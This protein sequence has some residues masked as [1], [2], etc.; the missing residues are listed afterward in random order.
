MREALDGAGLPHH[1]GRAGGGRRAARASPGAMIDFMPPADTAAHR[2]A[3]GRSGDPHRLADRHRGRLFHRSGNRRSSIPQH[4]GD[5]SATRQPGRT[6][7]R[8]RPHPARPQRCAATAGI[9]PF[10]VMSCDNIPH[11]GVVTRNAVA[12]LARLSDPAAGRLDRGAM[13]PSRTAWSTA[14]R[15]ATD[16]SRARDRARSDFGIE[17]AWP[18]FCEEFRQ[19]VLEDNFPHGRPALEAGRRAVRRPMSRP[20]RYMKIRILNGGHAIIAYPGGLL[21]IHFVHEAMEH[22]LIARFLAKVETRG[23]HPDR[24]ARAGHRPAR[25]LPPDRAALLQP[26]DRRHDPAAV[27]RRLEPP[28]QVHR[29]GGARPPDGGRLDRRAGARSRRCGAATATA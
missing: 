10:T 26:E 1:R 24:A 12:G 23:D 17:D 16:G 9:Q 2:R 13:S 29:A 11:N 25:L 4:P 18:V 20:S 19:W 7:D 21:D 5:R 27:P 28:A 8:L 15:P 3:A 22:P 14:S 6:R